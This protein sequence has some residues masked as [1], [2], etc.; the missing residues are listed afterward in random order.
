VKT[1]PWDEELKGLASGF[2]TLLRAIVATVDQYGL[3]ARHLG[4]HRREVDKFFQGCTGPDLRS[5]VAEGLRK[6]LL[7]YQ[8]K[9][10]AFLGHDGV[11]W[12]NN[13]AE[14]AL[15]RFA[16]YREMADGQMSEDGLNEYLVLLSVYQ[17]CKYKGVSCLKFLLSQETDIEVFREKGGKKRPVSSVELHPEGFRS[18]LSSRKRLEAVHSATAGGPTKEAAQAPG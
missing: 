8:D 9:L 4:K 6:R 15:K 12:N 5:E 1:N 11:P 13:N 17:T 16:Y 2:G 14:H 10:V 3:K 18:P 7:K